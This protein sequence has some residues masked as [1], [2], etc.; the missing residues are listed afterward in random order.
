MTDKKR[1]LFVDDRTKRIHYALNN[2]PDYEVTIATC[3]PEALRQLVSQEWDVV[4]LDH[5]LNGHDFQ[6]PDTP[7]GGS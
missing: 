6:D 5:D 4:S 2:Y 3:V 7:T 1:L